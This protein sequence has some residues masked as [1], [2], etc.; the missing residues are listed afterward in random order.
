MARRSDFEGLLPLPLQEGFTSQAVPIRRKRRAWNK[1]VQVPESVRLKISEAQKRRY[2]M[3]PNLRATMVAK[4]KVDIF[5][6]YFPVMPYK[7]VPLFQSLFSGCRRAGCAIMR[8]HRLYEI[9]N[10]LSVS[11]LVQGRVPWN[12]GKKLS[13]ETRER[14]SLAKQGRVLPRTVRRRIS[15]AHRGITHTAVRYTLSLIHRRF[16]ALSPLPLLYSYWDGMHQC[17]N[18]ALPLPLESS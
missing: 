1:G 6:T 18:V 17:Y 7:P 9:N 14:M 8:N 10:S 16:Q 15:K 2:R 4:L 3:S 11:D 12:K 13:L 5:V